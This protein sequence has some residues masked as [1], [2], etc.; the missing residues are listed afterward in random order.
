MCF[1][2]VSAPKN[3]ILQ[4]FNSL[5]LWWYGFCYICVEGWSNMTWFTVL[6]LK[7]APQVSPLGMGRQFELL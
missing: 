5:H 3:D 4:C 1:S 7:A 6:E 2:M